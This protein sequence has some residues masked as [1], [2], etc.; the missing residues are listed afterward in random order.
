MVT[1][2]ALLVEYH[3]VVFEHTILLDLPSMRR[4]LPIGLVSPMMA[5]VIANRY[6]RLMSIC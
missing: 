5:F 3:P 4:E 2:K 6:Y 1:K